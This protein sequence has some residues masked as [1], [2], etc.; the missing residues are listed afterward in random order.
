[1]PK[2]KIMFG[3]ARIGGKTHYG[4]LSEVPGV[5]AMVGVFRREQEER[6]NV[7]MVRLSNAAVEKID[8][9]VE[10]TLAGSRSEAAALL[11]N[12]GI[13]S[14]KDLFARME[15]SM[16]EIRRL[17]GQLSKLAHGLVSDDAG[18]A[19]GDGGGSSPDAS[20]FSGESA[21]ENSGGE[22]SAR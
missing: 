18:A 15:A 3:I 2:K 1:M 16:A 4:D 22:G 10:A 9:L 5:K 19:A 8:H 7:V 13:E 21:E 17:K 11:V 6:A 12:A 20:G 14:N